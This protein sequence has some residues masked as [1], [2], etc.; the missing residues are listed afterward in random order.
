MTRP[1]ARSA[2]SQRDRVQP[3]A[4]ADRAWYWIR[5]WFLAPRQILDRCRAA[6]W[7]SCR[8][9]TR[10]IRCV[11]STGYRMGAVTGIAGQSAGAGRRCRLRRR[12]IHCDGGRGTGFAPAHVR[13]GSEIPRTPARKSTNQESS[14]LTWQGTC[15]RRNGHRRGPARQ[16]SHRPRL[17]R[18]HRSNTLRRSVPP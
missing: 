11:E 13:T 10:S 14:C 7:R 1:R 12:W 15:D 2:R 17:P 16:C 6:A 3:P 18:S 9:G 5:D 8:A 4:V